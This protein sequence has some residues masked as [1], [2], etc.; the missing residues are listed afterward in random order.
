MTG[1]ARDRASPGWSPAAF[2][3][4]RNGGSGMLDII[5]KTMYAGLGLAFMTRERIE[6]FVNDLVEMGKITEQEGRVLYKDMADRSE[7]ARRDISERMNAMMRETMKRMNLV[8]RDEFEAL[9]RELAALR[10]FLIENKGTP[11]DRDA[12]GGTA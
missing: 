6:S 3:Q 12:G 1:P 4:E 8:P 5:R 10:E 2:R 11:G 7:E 9:K